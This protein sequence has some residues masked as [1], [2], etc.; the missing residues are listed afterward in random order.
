MP[1]ILIEQTMV[2]VVVCGSGNANFVKTSVP[3]MF[4]FGMNQTQ[5]IGVGGTKNDVGPHTDRTKRGQ[6]M[7]CRKQGNQ[8]HAYCVHV[9]TIKGIK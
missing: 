8:Y 2:H 5:V 3:H 6:C 4:V 7:A 9:M 1:K